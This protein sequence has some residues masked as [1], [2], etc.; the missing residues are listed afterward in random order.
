[1]KAVHVLVLLFVLVAVDF[2]VYERRQ[3]GPSSP[4]GH[5]FPG[6]GFAGYA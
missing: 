5:Y 3:F 4:T 2:F 1:M 6:A